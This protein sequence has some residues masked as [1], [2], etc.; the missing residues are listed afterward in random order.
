MSWRDLGHHRADEERAER[1]A[2][3]ELHRQQR[4]PKQRP[5]TVISSI[6]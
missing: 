1:D 6:S 2:V 3:V 5:S 4:D